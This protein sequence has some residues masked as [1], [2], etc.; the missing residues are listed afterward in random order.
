MAK[1]RIDWYAST[2]AEQREMWAAILAN[3][4]AVNATLRIPA[5]RLDRLKEMCTTWLEFYDK[6]QLNRA[7]VKALGKAFEIVDSGDKG[8]DPMPVPP[9]FHNLNL[10]S[11][12]FV[13]LQ[14]ELREYRDYLT[15]LFEWSDDMGDLLK[16]NG[17]DTPSAPDSD[18][19]ALTIGKI[20]N[21]TVTVKA[22]KGDADGFEFQHREAGADMWQQLTSSGTAETVLE[23]PA[24]AANASQKYEIRAV[25]LKNF[26]RIGEWSPT[27]SVVIG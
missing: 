2:L 23:L 17:S 21:N 11:A 4:D 3:I 25:R 26:K 6:L 15:S 20:L 5:Q 27:Y 12:D 18:A 24:A 9:T 7:A 13:G 8:T 14:S 19:F 10:I 16:L 1:K 22:V